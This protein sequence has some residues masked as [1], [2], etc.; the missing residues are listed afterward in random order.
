[1]LKS[2]VMF[3]ASPETYVYKLKN[4]CHRSRSRSHRPLKMVSTSK[5]GSPCSGVKTTIN[6]DDVALVLS[7][8]TELR[9]EVVI[10]GSRRLRV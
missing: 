10:S 4:S 8:I 3:G 1:M 6:L 2:N 7:I 9:V 5:G